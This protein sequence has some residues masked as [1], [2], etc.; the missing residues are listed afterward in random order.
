MVKAKSSEKIFS[1]G[2]C[3]PLIST[4]VI[5][6]SRARCWT[7]RASPQGYHRVLRERC[8]DWVLRVGIGRD[9]TD[10]RV[11]F[12]VRGRERVTTYPL[13]ESPRRVSEL[14]AIAE[15]AADV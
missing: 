12:H 2:N 13:S 4:V 9:R 1:T 10:A 3:A 11:W 7:R 14:V 5:H 6:P 15:R 8:R